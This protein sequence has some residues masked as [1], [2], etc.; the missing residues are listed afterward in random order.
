MTESDIRRWAIAVYWPE[1]PPR[2]YLDAG[3]AAASRAGRL[4]APQELNP[5]AWAPPPPVML[6]GHAEADHDPG[7]SRGARAVP[8]GARRLFGGCRLEF[9]VPIGVGDVVRRRT[10]LEGWTTKASGAGEM[11]LVDHLHEWRN[12]RDE[13]VRSAVYTLVY[14]DAP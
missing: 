13:M 2:R 12:H 5:F 6:D 7:A 4:V 9:G 14:R 3:A 11:V 1:P 8:E 10:C